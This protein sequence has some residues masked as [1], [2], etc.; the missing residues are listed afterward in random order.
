MFARRRLP[1]ITPFCGP[2]P[3]WYHFGRLRLLKVITPR[4]KGVRRA[5]AWRGQ[6]CYAPPRTPTSGTELRRVC[7]AAAPQRPRRCY[8]GTVQRDAH[9][10]NRPGGHIVPGGAADAPWAADRV[11]KQGCGQS[12]AP[13]RCTRGARALS[14]HDK[15]YDPVLSNA[16][17]LQVPLS[18]RVRESRIS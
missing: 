8:V 3:E 2:N 1:S 17:D 6:V 14:A 11:H 4:A 10:R 7:Y 13:H 18:V 9:R 15:Q 16:P 5:S 12:P